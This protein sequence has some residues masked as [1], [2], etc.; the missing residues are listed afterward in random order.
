MLDDD[1][2]P[3]LLTGYLL[4]LVLLWLVGALPGGVR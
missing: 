4:L 2:L 3:I 1:Y